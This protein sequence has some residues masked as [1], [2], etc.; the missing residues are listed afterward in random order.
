[1]CRSGSF[2]FTVEV[3]HACNTGER[4]RRGVRENL[5]TRSVIHEH[6]GTA[7]YSERVFGLVPVKPGCKH[8]W[9]RCR[10]IRWKRIKH[11]S[12]SKLSQRDNLSAS[13]HQPH[14]EEGGGG[15]SAPHYRS[16]ERGMN[17]RIQVTIHGDS[18]K[19]RFADSQ[20]LIS[21]ELGQRE[22]SHTKS[23][24]EGTD[25]KENQSC[26]RTWESASLWSERQD[27]EEWHV[28]LSERRMW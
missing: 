27:C 7:Q 8:I 25:H 2:L 21:F 1:M 9:H 3:I 20:T 6:E 16:L 4:C 24:G 11:T 26:G 17:P 13:Q 18:S 12:T 5:P 15:E 23:S 22:V 28:K 14:V 10:G 19:H